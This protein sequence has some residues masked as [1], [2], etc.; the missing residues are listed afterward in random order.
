[1]FCIIIFKLIK[2]LAKKYYNKNISQKNQLSESD[3][4]SLNLNNKELKK[5]I[6]A[7]VEFY[8]IG[9]DSKN[10]MINSNIKIFRTITQNLFYDVKEN[11]VKY[12]Y[13]HNDDIY[14]NLANYHEL[15]DYY[16]ILC[17]Q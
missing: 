1:M 7:G 13:L 17:K 12:H 3:F 2:N 4:F 16:I 14:L 15:Y 6:S 5:L 8:D 9:F 11:E 10:S